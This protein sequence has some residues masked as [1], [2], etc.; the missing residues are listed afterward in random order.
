MRQEA[1]QWFTPK[2]EGRIKKICKR[3][4]EIDEQVR[5]SPTKI[6]Q[7]NTRGEGLRL[8]L[9]DYELA[10]RN[11]KRRIESHLPGLSGDSSMTSF[12]VQQ[13]KLNTWLLTN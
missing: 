8:T 10:L 2:A 13:T 11:I 3:I 6:A 5:Q 9:D 1:L 7:L 4:E 12:I